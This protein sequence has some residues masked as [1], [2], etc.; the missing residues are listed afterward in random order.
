MTENIPPKTFPGDLEF[1]LDL[2]RLRYSRE[3]S[4]AEYR[5]N[6][7]AQFDT[8]MARV[9]AEAANDRASAVLRNVIWLISGDSPDGEAGSGAEHMDHTAHVIV[10]LI[11][12]VARNIENGGSFAIKVV[13][14]K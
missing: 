9:L 12:S 5:K 4:S 10:G 7:E 3:G 11:E 14:P 1:F 2:A 6:L 8:L 13:G